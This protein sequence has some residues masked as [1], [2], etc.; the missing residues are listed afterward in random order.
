MGEMNSNR[1]SSECIETEFLDNALVIIAVLDE[2][3]KIIFWNRAAETITGY[4]H[5]EVVGSAAV[6]KYLYPDKDYRRS[7]TEKIHEILAT[8]DFFKNLETT[9]RTQ[10]GEIRIIL[11]N[12]KQ[13]TRGS[14]IYAIAVG[15]DVTST[16]D[17][18]LFRESII[19]NANV[20]MAV[21]DHRGKILVWNKAAESITGYSREEVIGSREVWKRLYPDEIYRRIITRRITEII[22]AQRYFENLETTIVTKAGEERIISWNTREIGS[23]GNFKEIAIGRDITEQR[24]AEEALPEYMT[25]MAM[26]LKQPVEII[27]D[28][29][30]DVVNL[31]RGGKITPA[32][33]AMILDVQVRNATQIAVNAQEFQKSIVEKNRGIPEAYRKFLQK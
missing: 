21:L 33:M 14:T 28:N 30:Q 10:S 9:I 32:E 8:E 23:P 6:W 24:K 2:K 26:R 3:G 11:W 25:E 12:T 27:R 29:L 7:V 22:S 19:D 4:T 1:G 13:I 18:D 17:L 15:Q 16:R 31:L 5:D 20:L